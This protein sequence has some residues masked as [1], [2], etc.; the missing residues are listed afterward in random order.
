VIV[1]CG[2][3]LLKLKRRV[4]LSLLASLG[5]EQHWRRQVARLSLR[6]NGEHRL[7]SCSGIS[8]GPVAMS[9]ALVPGCMRRF[10]LASR[11]LCSICAECR[12]A[13]GPPE[14]E[15]GVIWI[16]A[17][18]GGLGSR[19]ELGAS[20]MTMSGKEKRGRWNGR[21]QGEHQRGPAFWRYGGWRYAPICV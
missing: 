4:E 6:A 18:G 14:G 5:R 9:A 15:F 3:M 7:T 1:K 16:S 10:E 13:A 21:R 19:G 12:L 8:G 11:R 20:A 2:E 17:A